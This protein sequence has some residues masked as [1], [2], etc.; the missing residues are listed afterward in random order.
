METDLAAIWTE[1]GI[2]PQY[3]VLFDSLTVG[4]HLWLYGSVKVPL[5]TKVQLHQHIAR[6]LKDVGLFRHRSKYVRALSGGMKRRL[7]IAISFIGDSKTVVLDEPTSSIDPCSRRGIWDILLKY[8]EGRTL[9]FTTHHLDEAEALSDRIA[10]LQHGQLSCCGS[11]SYLKEV[12]GQ[13][14]SL[15]FTKKPS[16][17]AFEDPGD[18]LRVTTLVQAY[19]PEAFLKEDSGSELTYMIPTR[20]DKAAFKGLFQALDE[21]LQYL[22]V[23]GYGISDTTLEK[24]CSESSQKAGNT[25]LIMPWLS[26]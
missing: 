17:F 19:I 26:S 8:K 13:G 24:V 21:N 2:C 9:I 20:A 4:E 7:S 6:A 11:P 5:W 10:I 16:V 18:T 3:D 22:H 12:Y 14:H 1:M 15:T 25:F 23:T